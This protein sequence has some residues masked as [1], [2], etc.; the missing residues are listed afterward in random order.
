MKILK[1]AIH[2]ISIIL[3]LLICIYA[4][5]CLPML[6]GYKPLVVL[7]GSM[8]PTFKAGSIIYYKE[9]NSYNDLKKGDIITYR[10]KNNY[11][12]HRIVDMNNNLFETKG[13][14]NKVS[15]PINISFDRVIGKDSN[16]S[17]PYLGYYIELINNHIILSIVFS[18]II[19]VSEF[20]FTDNVIFDIN[21]RKE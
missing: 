1:K 14:A 2:Y 6:F 18:I 21:K 11:V 13:D 7:S 20:L 8:E 16:I 5:V 17:I 3:Y 19:L 10:Y 12:S 15:D 4:I 9:V